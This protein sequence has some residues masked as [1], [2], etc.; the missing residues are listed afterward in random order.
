[1]VELHEAD[2][3]VIGSGSAGAIIA[4]RLSEDPG[5]SVL[6]VEA[7]PRDHSPLLH[8]PAA[9]RHAFN[10]RRYNWSYRSE[11]EP[12]LNG[13]RLA[14]PRGKV[15]G[16]SSSIN[17]LVYLRGHALDYESWAESGAT[18][19][20]YSEVLPYF[21]RL[22]RF[23]GPT[24]EYRGESG[25]VKVST[26]DDLNPISRAFMEA[27]AEAG[28]ELTDDVNGY[29]QEGFSRF[30][31][32]AAGGD[33][34]STARAYLHPAAHRANLAIRTGCVAER[35]LFEGRHAVAVACRH[36]RRRCHVRARREIILSA[37]AFN[38]PK[39]LM[40]SEVGPPD[41]LR[42]HDIEVRQELPGVG[43]NLQ[44]HQIS[45]VQ[46]SCKRP[47]S[48]AGR[49]SLPSRALAALRWALRRDGLLASN[50]FECGAFIRS[51]AGI[52]YPD[53]QLYCFPIAVAEGSKDFLRG[54]G[55]QVQVSPQRSPSRG[56]VEL[57][58]GDPE[59][60]P[61]IRFDYLS[62]EQDHVAFRAGIRLT[63]EILRQEA[64]RPY[65]GEELLPTRTG[66]LQRRGAG[67]LRP[68]PRPV[69]LPS[70]GNLPDGPGSAGGRR[71]AMPSSRSDRVEGRGCVHHARRPLVQHQ[72]SDHDDRGEG[73]RHHCR[74][75]PLAAVEPAVLRR[76]G[77]AGAPASPSSRSHLKRPD[78]IERQCT[79]RRTRRRPR[80]RP[81]DGIGSALTAWASNPAVVY[82][83][84]R[85]AVLD[86]GS[87]SALM[88]CF[89]MI[90]R[91]SGVPMKAV[92]C[93]SNSSTNSPSSLRKA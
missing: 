47:V 82:P 58:S 34:W 18:G 56:R 31:M 86:F 62:S 39:L 35:I 88:P 92:R 30:A 3:V 57:A 49:V 41:H 9:A 75:G 80:P 45:S 81:V 16:G 23:V 37:G 93:L 8:I 29:R 87:S 42:S 76:P 21:R 27:C 11:P 54:H 55:F 5:C 14:Q 46:L 90:A 59:A 24:S 17:G 65:R 74:A 83:P 78:P 32:N 69:L 36:H 52:R 22:E 73:G 1:M 2:Y 84:Q 89:S 61:S 25:P 43:R 33:R 72:L 6:L 50:H 48:L 19:W 91:C 63:R 10:A 13:R 68:R 51:A 67:S 66:G 15:L 79:W 26:A 64:M 12:G 7:G 60:A 40:L 4:A 70:I 20:S 28:Y 53:I 77:M 85:S 38:S 71:P 44:D